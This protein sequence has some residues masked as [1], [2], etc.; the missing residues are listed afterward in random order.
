MT[1]RSEPDGLPEAIEVPDRRFRPRRA[2]AS[3]RRTSRAAWWARSWPRPGAGDGVIEVVEPA[4][5]DV[6]AEVPRARA[7]ETD[8]AVAR[9]KAAFPD[10]RAVGP[11]DRAALLHA[12][13]DA[14]DAA[15]EDPR[16]TE[17][18]NAGK[19]IGDARAEMQMVVETFRSP[20]AAPRRCWATRS[21]CP[22]AWT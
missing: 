11:G 14:L 19:P 12:L 10:W 17:A 9:A 18:R 5:S 2:L 7:E 20:R 21:R 16:R 1:G 3:R 4:T 8:A 22:E 6:M 13:A 15:H